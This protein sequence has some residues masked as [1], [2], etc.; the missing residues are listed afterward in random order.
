MIAFVADRARAR[1]LRV[2]SE[3]PGVRSP[4]RD[5]TAAWTLATG[6]GRARRGDDR[7]SGSSGRTGADRAGALPR[8]DRRHQRRHRCMATLLGAAGAP[9]APLVQPLAAPRA[10]WSAA[11]LARAG[12]RGRN[13]PRLAEEP[14]GTSHAGRVDTQAPALPRE[15]GADGDGARRL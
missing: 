4:D 15:A 5:G 9:G 6:S 13:L 12:A 14:S 3:C 2:Q 1:A 11:P 8:M 10:R 7:R